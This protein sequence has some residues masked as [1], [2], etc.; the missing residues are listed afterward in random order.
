MASATLTAPPERLAPPIKPD[1][2]VVPE[3]VV[4]P[5]SLEAE[6]CRSPQS[7]GGHRMKLHGNARLSVK[8]REPLI[9]RVEHDRTARTRRA[10]GWA[11]IAPRAAMGCSAALRSTQ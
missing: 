2:G 8:G 9:D 7:Q 6:W 10:S 3:D 1:L 5:G 11:D 4:H